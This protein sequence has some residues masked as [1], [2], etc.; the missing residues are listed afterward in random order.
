MNHYRQMT[1]SVTLLALALAF[2]VGLSAQISQPVLGATNVFI[3][4]L[5]YD[6]AGSDTGEAVEIAGPAGTNLTGWSLVLYNGSN[7]NS[8]NTI[9]LSNV[10]PNQQNGCGTLSFA[11]AGIQNGSPDGLALLDA[12]DNV[13]QFLSYEGS[14]TANDGPATGMT[15]TDIGVAEASNTAIGFSLQLAGSGSMYEDFT[16]NAA[17]ANTFEAPNNGQIFTNCGG[18]SDAPPTVASTSPSNGDTSVAVDSNISINFSEDVTVTG[19]W[20]EISCSASGLHTAAVSGG[21]QSFTLDP[22]VDFASGENCTITVFA[23]QVTD[24]DGTVDNMETDFSWGF[25]TATNFGACSNPA[26]LIHDVQGPGDVSPLNG[27]TGV[28]IEGVVVGDFQDTSTQ[29]GGFFL[30][31]E[32]D[33][34]D[35]NSQTSEGIF[36]FDDGFG[37]DVNMGQVVRVQGD[38]TEFFSLTEVTNVSNVA[39]CEQPGT[40]TAAT[41]N[42]PVGAI[43]DLEWNEGML[44]NIPQTLHATDNFNWHRNGEVTLSVGGPLDN[45]TNVT[46]PG[47]AALALQDLNNRSQIQLDDGSS[48]RSPD[49]DPV[50]YIEPDGTLRRGATIPSLTG[51]LGFA[52]GAYEVHPTTDLS[53]T[54][55]N[56]RPAVP[57][58][59]GSLKIAAFNVLNYFTN[60][61]FIQDSSN[62][63]DPADD[64]CGP[65]SDQ[66]CR[67]ADTQAELDNQKAKIVAAISQLDADIVGLI[68][69]ENHPGDVPTADLVDGLNAVTGAG[70]Y[71]Y[72]A[73]GAIGVD[74]IRVALIYKPASVSPVGSFAI[75]D[76]SVDPTFND[77]KNRP[78]LAQTF[79]E[80]GTND[81]VTVAVNHLKSKGSPCDDV[82]DPDA[83]DGQGNCN[84]IRTAAANAM[85]NWLATDPTGSGSSDYLIT[86]DL[87][88][89][90]LEDPIIAIEGAGYTDLIE[91]FQ[92]ANEYSF[93]FFGQSGYLDHGLSSPSLTAR[94]TGAAFWHINADEPRGL[95]Y[96][97]ENNQP[98][99]YNPDQFR[100]SDHDP[101]LVGICETTPP[102]VDLTVSPNT[103]WPPNHRY[104][105]VK[106]TVNVT[107]ADPNATATLLSVTSNEPDTGTGK[108]DKPNDIVIIDD[109]TINLRAERAGDG[110]GR[111]Y[112]ITYEATDA[113]GNS[114]VASAEVS[115]PHDQ[116]QGDENSKK[117]DLQILA[118]NDFHGNIA[119][120]SSGFGGTGRADFLAT[121]IR[122]AEEAAPGHSIFVSAGDLIG[123]SPLISAL[124]H[125]EPTIEAM[126]LMGLDINAVGNHEFDEGPAELLR[127]QFGG[128]H[129]VDGDLDGDPFAGADFEFLAA[130]VV[131]DETGE[132]IFPP[133]TIR[134]F[135]GV[136]VAFIGMT[137]EGTPSIVTPS[138]VEG[139]TFNDEAETVNALVPQLQQ[140]NI[141]S[142][143]VLLHEG[144]FSPG[145][146]NDCNGGLFGP[147][148][149]I[150]PQLDD[151]VDLV[152]AGHTNDEFVCEIDGK[153]VTMAD[154]RGRLFTDIDVTLNRVTKDMT[155]EAIN[156]VPNLQAGVTPDR[157]LTALI[158]KYDTLSAP[159][160]NAVIGTITEDILRANNAAGES[161]LGDVIADAQL[162][163]TAPAGFGDAV[164]AFM[165]PGGIRDDL[166]FVSGGPEADG[167]VTFGEAFSVQPFGNSLVTMSLSGAQIDALLEQQF[168]NPDPGNNRILQVS[169]GFTYEWSASA[170]TGSKVDPATIMINGVVVDPVA[171]YRV[172]VNSFLADGGDNFS[173]LLE[174]TD[175]L[176]G[177]VDLDALAAYF[178]VNSPV[179]PGPQ[180]RIT[181]AP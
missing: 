92:S 88:A 148:A 97:Q 55:V 51:V 33:Q 131:V 41:V 23:S 1:R 111:I 171:T 19:S 9:N 13:V 43:A 48:V 94:V 8:Y 38:V 28:V 108:G 105:T 175:R 52:F 133:Y 36:V 67:G 59:G 115:V 156:N 96:N 158:D 127:M 63:N 32:D 167:E 72:I 16:W 95:D 159:L 10:I 155:I 119:S 89:Y 102:E 116:G 58:V 71:D 145:G 15:S 161:A 44:I 100:S 64:I 166:N 93:V 146:Q 5:H 91:A 149:E 121:N 123:A 120:T 70:T 50:P 82:G 25:D 20:F 132:T 49:L 142:I 151:A 164:V 65:A 40:A 85:I 177:E 80:N 18:V 134:N 104:V 54:R 173:V 170:P 179:P 31:E 137:L 140:N 129:P 135:Q 110:A 113:C 60:I 153:W 56:D 39:I 61:D 12:D 107:D 150:V 42:L 160:A 157:A 152:I 74:V 3:N 46:T 112:T 90:A 169:T 2:V 30:Q 147:I 69:I 163:A 27:A 62:N 11:Q 103:L 45:P 180:D 106:A 181:L 4:E 139:L 79:Q 22:D 24:Q 37:V 53:F 124:F 99:L 144:G 68:E 75:L 98:S 126:N 162:A 178:A 83:G 29:L 128:S 21:P 66:E 172:T 122:D 168:D 77:D 118:I 7:G 174:G 125:D 141:E 143:V 130:N 87:N 165:N 34:H 26:T 47:A 136:K 109:F 114:T 84:G 86:G 117:V 81:L 138:G 78:V 76:A 176:G 101:V 35:D 6:N 17:A 154:T 14:F 73:T 57:D